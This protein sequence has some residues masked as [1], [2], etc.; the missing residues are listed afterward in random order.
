MFVGVRERGMGEDREREI[1]IGCLPYTCPLGI[2]HTTFWCTGQ[3]T[4]HLSQLAR[5]RSALFLTS[6]NDSEIL[7]GLDLGCPSKQLEAG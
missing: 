6:P 2:K 5:T 7:G 3:G 4:N 1:S